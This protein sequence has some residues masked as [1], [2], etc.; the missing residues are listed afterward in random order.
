MSQ[1]AALE[2]VCMCVRETDECLKVVS[3]SRE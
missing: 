3:D 2:C 1:A